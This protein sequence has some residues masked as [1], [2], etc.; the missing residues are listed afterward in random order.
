MSIPENPW[1]LQAEDDLKMAK[2]AFVIISVGAMTKS[3]F[4]I[5]SVN[6]ADDSLFCTT[7]TA[8]LVS[9]TAIIVFYPHGSVPLD[10]A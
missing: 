10:Q 1:F 5:K 3:A 8:T 2:L 9:K 6:R 4:A 7:S